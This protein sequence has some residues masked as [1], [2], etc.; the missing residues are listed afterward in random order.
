MVHTAEGPKRRY[1]TAKTRDEVH[2]KLIEALG[3]RAQGLNFDAGNLKLPGLKWEDVD[4]ERGVLRLRCALVR[5]G[6]KAA[7]GNLKTP[8][9]AGASG[10]PVPSR[11]HG[12]PR[13]WCWTARNLGR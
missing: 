11:Y 10:S 13:M 4:L 5:E 9:A 12:C 2:K 6:G 1:V 3:N 8:G 7:L